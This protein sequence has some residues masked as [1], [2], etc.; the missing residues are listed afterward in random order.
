MVLGIPKGSNEC[1]PGTM[2]LAWWHEPTMR[3][4]SATGLGVSGAVVFDSCRI[5]S[6]YMGSREPLTVSIAGSFDAGMEVVD[7]G[8]ALRLTDAEGFFNIVFVNRAPG[9]GTLA[10]VLRYMEEHCAGGRPRP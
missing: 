9:T 5:A 7:A 3:P 2:G 1:H 6:R 10:S 4:P 8:G